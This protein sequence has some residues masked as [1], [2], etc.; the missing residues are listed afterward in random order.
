[1]PLSDVT[2]AVT[3]VF[4]R[5]LTKP[6]MAMPVDLHGKTAIVTGT[7]PGSIGYETAKTLA[8]WGA[9]VIITTRS[10][11]EACVNQ[12]QRELQEH[13]FHHDLF[14]HPL[15]LTLADSVETFV[16]WF[17]NT[18][19]S[20]LHILIN[21]AGIHADILGSWTEPHLSSDGFEI[22]WRTN[23]MGPMHLTTRLIPLMEQ[24]ATA[25][26]PARVVF[27]ASHLHQK[28]LNSEIFYASRPYNSWQTYGQSKLGLVHAAFELQRRY[29]Q[30][31]IQSYVLHPGSIATNIAIKGLES[32]K[33]MQKLLQLVNP[34]Q[35]YFMLTPIQGAQT[36]IYCATAPGLKGGRYF[37]R[38]AS[39]QP[40]P[41]TDNTQVAKRLWEE[42]RD[43][44]ET[45][46]STEAPQNKPKQAS[47]A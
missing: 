31:N 5:L 38:C 33:R 22:H 19:A 45:L 29:E 12:M 23:F 30:N 24:S 13:G 20:T 34:L 4:R 21:N 40:S 41:E 3:S 2:T 47:T 14:G 43:W 35:M 7:S 1:M 26:E 15:D 39:A 10:N 42:T 46:P 18:F 9:R 32:N 16:A 27:V 6:P 28:G 8:A 36:Q 37:D 17:R 11:T 25:S 44:I